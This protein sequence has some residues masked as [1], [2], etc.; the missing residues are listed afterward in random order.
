MAIDDVNTMETNHE[1]ES[2]NQHDGDKSVKDDE[3]HISSEN[4]EF[5]TILPSKP[6]TSTDDNKQMEE[7]L[8]E[9]PPADVYEKPKI[10]EEPIEP[11]EEQ[12][13]TTIKPEL[14]EL[15]PAHVYDVPKI[16][17][18]TTEEHTTTKPELPQLPELSTDTV[19]NEDYPAD[20]P[21]APNDKPI[22]S[23]TT[24]ES[25]ELVSASNSGNIVKCFECKNSDPECRMYPKKAKQITCT[26][27][28]YTLSNGIFFSFCFL[29]FNNFL[30]YFFF[31][32][33]K[34]MHH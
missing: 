7:S 22:N 15:P 13:T 20:Q 16:P 14:P 4:F 31:R 1:I 19:G 30:N 28:C 32:I 2:E 11:A 5:S 29:D 27:G 12:R 24:T 6:S 23:E 10:P 21:A 33:S 26:N 17:E 34:R 9:L 25:S 3:N 18:E 8:P